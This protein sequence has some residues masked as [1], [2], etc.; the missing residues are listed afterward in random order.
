MP[1]M[2]GPDLRK[3]T[4]NLFEADCEALARLYGYGWSEKVRL[5]VREY[6][7]KRGEE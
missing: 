1:R 4:L 5:L 6:L 2:A 7:A 3:V